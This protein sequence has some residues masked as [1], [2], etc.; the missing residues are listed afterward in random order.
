VQRDVK[1]T[2]QSTNFLKLQVLSTEE[3][4]D[5]DEAFVEFRVWFKSVQKNDSSKQVVHTMTERSRF[6]KEDDRW[7]YLEAVSLD[8]ASHPCPEA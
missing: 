7:L 4:K 5:S 8:H 1:A 6:K 2:A 3:E